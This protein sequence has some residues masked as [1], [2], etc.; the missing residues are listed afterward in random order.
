[1]PHCILCK[2]QLKKGEGHW[3]SINQATNTVNVKA[4]SGEYPTLTLRKKLG[5]SSTA[6]RAKNVSRSFLKALRQEKFQP[7]AQRARDA[8]LRQRPMVRRLQKRLAR[9]GYFET[10][11]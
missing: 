6:S 5:R 3:F 7:G 8:T 2:K 9:C 11:Y 4:R 10:I 1:M